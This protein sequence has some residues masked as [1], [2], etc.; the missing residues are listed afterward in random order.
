MEVIAFIYF[1]LILITNWFAIKFNIALNRN[2]KENVN[3]TENEHRKV[4]IIFPSL[5]ERN[6]V[7]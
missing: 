2:V 5:L 7:L 1:F 4:K 6:L 3:M